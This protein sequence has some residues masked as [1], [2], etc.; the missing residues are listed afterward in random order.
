M[1]CNPDEFS[2][3][4]LIEHT[5]ENWDLGG[6]AWSLGRDLQE[7]PEQTSPRGWPALC[8][9]PFGFQ[10]LCRSNVGYKAC[11]DLPSSLSNPAWALSPSHV[12]CLC[13]WSYTSRPLSMEPLL[14]FLR[15][16][17]H[18]A[19]TYTHTEFSYL[20]HTE[21]RCY[22]LQVIPWPGVLPMRTT[23]TACWVSPTTALINLYCNCLFTLL[24]PVLDYSISR[25]GTVSYLFL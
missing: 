21:P 4:Q 2:L 13:S 10:T 24:S 18:H 22:F 6:S 1:K 19:H 3:D 17:Q 12:L 7:K 9:T 15:T 25:A 16:P 5:V 8:V 23:A 11:S 14:S 20:T